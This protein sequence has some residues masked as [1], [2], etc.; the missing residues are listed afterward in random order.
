MSSDSQQAAISLACPNVR[1]V[2]GAPLAARDSDQEVVG[3]LTTAT[4]NADQKRS[5]KIRVKSTRDM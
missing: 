2:A 5:G 3:N 4:F 1:E